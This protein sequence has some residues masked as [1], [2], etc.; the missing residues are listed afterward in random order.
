VST[1]LADLIAPGVRLALIRGL[2]GSGKSTL[3]RRLAAEHGWV[4][5]EADQFF[6]SECS[7]RFDASR[8]ADAHAWCLRHASARLATGARVAIA[9]TFVS[10]WELSSYLGLAEVHATPYRIIEARGDWPSV[11][12]VPQDVVAQ[13]RA[14]WERLPAHLEALA[15]T[16]K[17]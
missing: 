10:L 9:N 7:Y 4:H 3:A 14:R 2:P 17:G 6:E 15:R 1:A 5:L 8:L 12:A 16:W 13:M 11:H